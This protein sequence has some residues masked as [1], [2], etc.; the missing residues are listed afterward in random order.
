MSVAVEYVVTLLGVDY[1]CFLCVRNSVSV[2]SYDRPSVAVN[3]ASK[4]ILLL[5]TPPLSNL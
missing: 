2:L 4:Y 3:L 1:L 5:P